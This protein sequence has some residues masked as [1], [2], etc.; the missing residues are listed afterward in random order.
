MN[1]SIKIILRVVLFLTM[2]CAVFYVVDKTLQFKYDDGVTTMEDFYSY[3]EDSIDVI[4]LGSSHLGVNVDT[5][6][7]CNQY[8]IASYK[9]WGSTQPVWNAYYNLVE[10]LKTQHPKVVVLEALGFSH[11]AEYYGYVN[12]VKNT[13]GLRWSRN[14]LEAIQAS[15]EPGDIVNALFPL[16]Q[17]HSR[18]S[19]LE[20]KD[21]S[22]YFWDNPRSEH[23]TKNWDVICPMD[24]P[25]DTTK[26]L[27]IAEKQLKY[28]KKIVYLCQK[29]DIPLLVLTAPYTAPDEERARFNTLNDLL[30]EE[31]IDQLDCLTNYEEY[32]FDFATDFGDTAGHLNSTGCAKL[33]SVL[34]EYLKSHYDLPDR[35]GDPLFSYEIPSDA[36]Y[37]LGSEFTGNGTSDFVD[38]RQKL[39]TGSKD[40]TIFTR[41][42]TR[43][44][45]DE[46]VLFSCF[47]E[48]E[49]YRG[50]LVRLADD[51]QL[52]VVVGDNYYTKVELPDKEK[53]TLAV[54]KNGDEY[55]IYL[56]GE[57][58]ENVQTSCDNYDG[59]L[60]LGAERMANNTLGRLSAVSIDKF[61][62]YDSA[63]SGAEA[64]KWTEENKVIPSREEQ[65]AA[66]QKKYTGIAEY[67][68]PER[69]TGSGTDCIDTGVQLYADPE[70]GWRLTAD[71]VIGDEDGT[72]LSCF[73]EEENN[74]H[75]LL[76]RKTQNTLSVQVGNSTLFSTVVYDSAQSELVIEKHGTSYTVTLDGVLLG[77]ADS[78]CD[79]Y[80]GTLLIDAERGYDLEPFRQSVL[81]VTGLQVEPLDAE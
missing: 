8:G 9:L 10:A 79:A 75:G 30:T 49:P 59:T 3:P 31:G 77:T 16:S 55:F 27:P 5:T 44:S 71:L 70:A 11:D 43:C 1:R 67:S 25:S 51:N 76:V 73:N 2:F 32:G 48:T 60:L 53:V 29:N 33:S 52:D 81:T 18:Y 47:S 56:E 12:A 40:W 28:F 4:L 45:S 72:Y 23:N 39:Y 74:Y 58:V 14:K 19:E 64:E 17:Y 62:L 37:A 22:Y 46:K 61:E 38:T 50:L 80:Y 54:T 42:S 63:K 26:R 13:M 20:S 65:L 21:F 35:T 57:L 36:V 15:Y 6:I 24:A 78:P 68:L 34:G 69:F 66:L 7:L 41:F